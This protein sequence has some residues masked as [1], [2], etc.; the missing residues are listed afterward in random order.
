MITVLFI[1]IAELP[2]LPQGTEE[3]TAQLK[4]AEQGE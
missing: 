1:S 2:Q 4:D 3:I